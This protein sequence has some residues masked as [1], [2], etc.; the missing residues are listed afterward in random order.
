MAQ[1]LGAV[2]LASGHFAVQ[3]GVHSRT[4]DGDTKKAL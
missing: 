1:G 2:E 4:P 3:R